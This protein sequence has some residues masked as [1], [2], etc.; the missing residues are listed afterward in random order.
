MKIEWMRG[1]EHT[2]P[3]SKLIK[4]LK[5]TETVD[6]VDPEQGSHDHKNEEGHEEAKPKESEFA[7]KENEAIAAPSL[8]ATSAHGINV[9]A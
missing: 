1:I 5:K 8:N 9:L 7:T 3:L 4:S 6:A 2:T